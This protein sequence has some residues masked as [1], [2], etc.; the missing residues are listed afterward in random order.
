[1]SRIKI[2][3][4]EARRLKAENKK[5][6][7]KVR[8]LQYSIRSWRDYMSLPEGEEIAKDETSGG[9]LAWALATAQKLG[10]TVIARWR[11]DRISY[12]ALPSPVKE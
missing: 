2:S 5:L 3:Q 12:I 9:S 10:H 6:S 8:D 1:M 4:A 11:S 7:Q